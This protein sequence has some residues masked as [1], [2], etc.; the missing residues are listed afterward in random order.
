MR[1]VRLVAGLS[2]AVATAAASRAAQSGTT[3]QYFVARLGR[4][5][6]ALERVTRSATSVQSDLFLTTPRTRRVHYASTE[7]GRRRNS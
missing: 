4:D 7:C 6:V 3:T 5:T 1:S 2:I